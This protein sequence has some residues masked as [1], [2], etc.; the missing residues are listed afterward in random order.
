VH[1]AKTMN[2]AAELVVELAAKQS[3]QARA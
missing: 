3:A 1:P 2:E